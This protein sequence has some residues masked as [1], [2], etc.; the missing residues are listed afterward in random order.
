MDASDQKGEWNLPA[1]SLGPKVSRVVPQVVSDLRAAIRGYL[2]RKGTSMFGTWSR[3]FFI[4]HE[5]SITCHENHMST[6][7]IESVV[8]LTD[9]VIKIEERPDCAFAIMRDGVDVLVLRAD[10]ESERATW[11]AA[12]KKASTKAGEVVASAEVDYVLLMKS[13]LYFR[14]DMARAAQW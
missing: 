11:S 8:K 6:S 13:A 4:V 14:A 3:R 5:D 10:E 7:K 12:I 2:W 9:G 1:L